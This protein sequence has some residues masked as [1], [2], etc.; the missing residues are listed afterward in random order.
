MILSRVLKGHWSVSILASILILGGLGLTQQAFGGISPPFFVTDQFFTVHEVDASEFFLA[1]PDAC[2][3]FHWHAASGG[4]V[5]STLGAIIFD[6]DPPECGYGSDGDPLT[7][8][9][10]TP[11]GGTSIPI[12]TTALLVAGAQTISPWLILGVIIP[13]GIGLAVFTLKRNH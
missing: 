4:F 10:E 13:V 2:F 6:P 8:F 11:V 9:V 12:D 3:D 1:G 5:T 7:G